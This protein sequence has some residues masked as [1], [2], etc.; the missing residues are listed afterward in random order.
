[1]KPFIAIVLGLSIAS[2]SNSSDGPKVDCPSGKCPMVQV[3][4]EIAQGGVKAAVT[5]PAKVVKQ[6]RSS[7]PV[8]SFFQRVF[9]RR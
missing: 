9:R 1:M 6:V 8:R 7:R 4:K 2:T 3:P 5:A